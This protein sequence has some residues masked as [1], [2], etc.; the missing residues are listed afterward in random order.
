MNCKNCG[1]GIIKCADRWYHTETQKYFCNTNHAEP[2]TLTPE[3]KP[4]G[5]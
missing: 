4:L 2:P 5:T 3:D 1:K